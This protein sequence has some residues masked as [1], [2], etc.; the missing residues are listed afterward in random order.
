VLTHGQTG[1]LA[2]FSD[3]DGIVREGLAVLDKPDNYRHLG[4][5][6][7]EHVGDCYSRDS[8]LPA[9]AERFSML[10]ATRRQG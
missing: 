4:A 10:A 6:A 2:D 3:P 1:L 8:C 5:A 7:A 9:I